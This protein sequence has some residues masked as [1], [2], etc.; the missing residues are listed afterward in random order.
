MNG[1][2]VDWFDNI[3]HYTLCLV[4]AWNEILNRT[5]NE[6]KEWMLFFLIPKT[7][8]EKYARPKR[9]IIILIMNEK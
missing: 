4:Y 5:K 9:N 8:R 3:A 2:P 6:H 1:Y 7:E